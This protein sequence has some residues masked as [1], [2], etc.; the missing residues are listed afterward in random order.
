MGVV[1]QEGLE[2]V[3]EVAV[4]APHHRGAKQNW[5]RRVQG[6]PEKLALPGDYKVAEVP[7][8]IGWAKGT[9]SGGPFRR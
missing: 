4:G 9:G 8:A 6:Q 1:G 7:F 3:F 2:R 5:S